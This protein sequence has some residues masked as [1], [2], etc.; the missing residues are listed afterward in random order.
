MNLD[1]LKDIVS[2]KAHSPAPLLN[3]PVQLLVMQIS[4]QLITWKLVNAFKHAATDSSAEVQSGHQ[5]EVTECGVVVGPDGL[6]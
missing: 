1:G 3:T 2:P 5:K 6:V 4:N